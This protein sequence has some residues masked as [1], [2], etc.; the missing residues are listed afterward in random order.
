MCKCL[1][2]FSFYC[3][4]CVICIQI[5]IPLLFWTFPASFFL[6]CV[7]AFVLWLIPKMGFPRGVLPPKVKTW[8]WSA[9][10][11]VRVSDSLVRC[12]ARWMAR[13]NIT[14]SVSA[15]LAMP[16]W[17][18]WSILPRNGTTKKN[19]QIRLGPKHLTSTPLLDSFERK[20]KNENSNGY[21]VLHRLVTQGTIR[22]PHS[23]W[24]YIDVML[25]EIFKVKECWYSITVVL[26]F[27]KQEVSFGIL[28]EDLYG[29]LC[30][31][32]NG[33]VT[34][35]VPENL[36]SHV[37]WLK[38]TWSHQKQRERIFYCNKNKK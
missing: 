9:V 7:Q 36:E 20:L 31:L 2:T 4:P 5:Q 6:D 22:Y 13:S 17:W 21:S 25:G 3:F 37:L 24:W 33:G 23:S 26:I 8:E 34:C 12:A 35:V 1:K 38:Q 19:K 30:H 18:P 11:T 32:H 14:A 16:S 29:L 15:S 27:H 10:T 28:A